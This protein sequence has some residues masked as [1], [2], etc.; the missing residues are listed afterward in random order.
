[1]QKN[2]VNTDRLTSIVTRQDCLRLLTS[3]IAVGNYHFCES[4]SKEWLNE[5][6]GDLYVNFL[7]AK[8]LIANGSIDEAEKILI[9][10]LDRDPEFIEAWQLVQS[11][12]TI[13]RELIQASIHV[14]GGRLASRMEIPFWSLALRGAKNAFKKGDY[15]SAGKLLHKSLPEIH[16]SPLIAISHLEYLNIVADEKTCFEAAKRYLEIW[17]RCVEIMISRAQALMKIGDES[18]AIRSLI[19]CVQ[20]D[21]GGQCIQR[22]KGNDHRFAYLWPTH[23]QINTNMEIPTDIQVGLGWRQLPDGKEAKFIN[24]KPDSIKNISK[25]VATENSKIANDEANSDN[26]KNVYVIV[27]SESGLNK[28]YGTKSSS[29]IFEQLSKLA[30]IISSHDE[31]ESVIFIPDN[32]SNCAQFNLQPISTIDPWKVKLSITDLDRYLKSHTKRIAAMLIIGGDQ[33]IPLH[34]LPNPTDDSDA[35]ILSDNPYGA[36]DMNY[37]SMC[38]PVGRVVG[39]KGSDP[40]LLLKQIR[41]ITM[42]H[43][44]RNEKPT[45]WIWVKSVISTLAARLGL[46]QI[47]TEIQDSFGYSAS[48]WKRSTIA[49]FRPLG[50]ANNVRVSPPYEDETII[51][52]DIKKAKYAFFNLHGL[53]DTSEWYGQRDVSDANNGVDYPVAIS[54]T[55]IASAEEFKPVVFTEACYGGQI[56][57]KSINESVALTLMDSGVPA[58]IASTGI[59]YG[60]ITTPLIGADLLA[61][62]FWKYMREGYS[63]GESLLKAKEGFVKIMHERQGFL[64]GEDQKTLISFVLYGDPLFSFNKAKLKLVIEKQNVDS[65]ST[66]LVNDKDGYKK[67]SNE[68]YSLKVDSIREIVEGYLPGVDFNDLRIREHH[69]I[70]KANNASN[71]DD[72]PNN[73]SKFYQ[74]QFTRKLN[75]NGGALNQFVRVTLD[76]KGK[77]TK[78]AV[79]R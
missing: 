78:L 38:W 33:I 31:W 34:G 25:Q 40:G 75:I 9:F 36:S 44:K 52:S 69:V 5:F 18:Q 62:I 17:P 26:L 16:K 46:Y 27:T 55:N 37:F 50:N 53:P 23:L 24:Q 73:K 43:E 1:M 12:S 72:N 58:L 7:F 20:N 54:A 67:S 32:A 3:S 74:I 45:F 10:I 76:E 22:K 71:L 19:P 65:K 49:A 47:G 30:S 68:I 61:F 2:N 66:K 77:I 13:N 15:V 70:S 29:V 59:A 4:L 60:S 41:S 39:E 6:K 8:A 56:E 11:I 63:A 42:Y 79:S 57:N 48:V 21:I 28:S 14:L 51:M 35:E 64:D